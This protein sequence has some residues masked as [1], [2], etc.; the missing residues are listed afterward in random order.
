MFEPAQS[1]ALFT[2]LYQLTMAQA[3]HQ[4]GQSGHATFSLY[5]RNFPPNRSFYVFCGLEAV[6]DSLEH[7]SFSG[8]DMEALQALDVFDTD[9]LDHLSTVRFTG[10]VRAMAEGRYSSPTSRY[11]K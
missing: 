7:L 11:S 2:D 10:A 3:Y 8:E 1:N 5:F 9:F 4:S 6:L